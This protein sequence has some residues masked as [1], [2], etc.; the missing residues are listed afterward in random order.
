M[1]VEVIGG[2][3]RFYI[4]TEELLELDPEQAEEART[5]LGKLPPLKIGRYG[6]LVEWQGG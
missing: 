5:A 2:L 1:D 4:K 3:L 6:Q